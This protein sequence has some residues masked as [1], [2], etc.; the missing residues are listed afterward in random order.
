MHPLRILRSQRPRGRTVPEATG[1]D[2]LGGAA[3]KVA[4]KAEALRRLVR[5]FVSAWW[6][7]F[8]GYPWTVW[9]FLTKPFERWYVRVAGLAV[10][11]T[12]ALTAAVNAAL[13]SVNVRALPRA[14]AAVSHV[15]E[16][17]VRLG[18]VKYAMPVTG[19]VGATPLA[20]LGP[21]SLGPSPLEGSSVEVQEVVVKVAPLASLLQRAVV[22]RVELE[23]A[24][25]E[26]VQCDNFS[27]FGFP[28][29]TEP[30]CRDFLPGLDKPFPEQQPRRGKPPRKPS[31][32]A[33]ATSSSLNGS[34]APPTTPGSS[35]DNDSSNSK[36]DG[37]SSSSS[38]RAE[39]T[40]QGG[41]GDAAALEAA[42][43]AERKAGGPGEPQEASSAHAP[44]QQQQQ[45]HLKQQRHRRQQQ[46]QQPPEEN[47]REPPMSTGSSLEESRAIA[48]RLIEEQ[49]A[50]QR[51][52]PELSVPGGKQHQPP[53]P[54]PAP[55]APS[56]AAAAA[57]APAAAPQAATPQGHVW[58]ALDR[59]V[60]RKA[61]LNVQIFGEEVPRA[62][63][64]AEAFVSL[65]KGYR[66][67]ELDVKGRI[68]ERDPRNKKLTMDNAHAHVN[69]RPFTPGAEAPA[70]GVGAAT[71]FSIQGARVP[72]H[73]EQQEIVDVQEK[74]L[75]LQK[76]SLSCS[77]GGEEG[78]EEGRSE[79]PEGGRGSISREGIKGAA[80]V[81]SLSSSSET[82]DGEEGEGGGGGVGEK[83]KLRV[84]LVARHIGLEDRWPDMAVSIQ[85]EDLHAPNVERL[86]PIPLDINEGRVSGEL[87]LRSHNEETWRF[88]SL[89]GRVKCRGL[90]F[91]FWD[92]PDSLS[93][94]N[95]DLLFE[96]DRLYLHNASGHFGAVP[97]T[98]AGDMDIN[99][100]GGHYRLS[101]NVPSVDINAL[102]ASLGARPLP[103]SVS[104][105]IR[106]VL[107][108][109]GPLEFPVFSGTAVAI[110]PTASQAA[111]AEDTDAK[112]AMLSAPG[113][114]GAY[115]KVPVLSASAVFTFD[116]STAAC[117]VHSFQAEPVGGGSLAGSGRLWLA[118]EAERDPRA[119]RFQMQGRSL[120]ASQLLERYAGGS[121][122]PLGQEIGAL[123]VKGA[124]EG[125]L[126]DATIS[127]RWQVPAAGARGNLE[128]TPSGLSVTGAS[129]TFNAKATAHT[130]LPD[131]ALI[132]AA[133]TQSE[134]T[135]AGKPRYSGADLDL[136][137]Q[138]F[139]AVPP[140]D[141]KK[142]QQHKQQQQQE[143]PVRLK[144]SGRA[145]L[146]GK[147]HEDEAGA[148]AFAGDL[149][150]Q[151]L[152][153]NQLRL[154]R[155]LTGKLSVTEQGAVLKA[156]GQRPDE[157]LEALVSMP[158]NLAEANLAPPPRA[159]Q[160]HQ[161]QQ[162]KQQQVKKEDEDEEDKSV[163]GQV[164][165]RLGRL[166]LGA[167]VDEKDGT[168]RLD[169]KELP[170]DELELGSL[171]GTVK[172]AAL[173]CRLA[174]REARGTIRVSGPR[175]NGLQGQ[176]LVGDAA[177]DGSRVKL[178]RIA[179]QQAR[180]SYVLE[181]EYV[182]PDASEVPSSPRD[183]A[184]ML[185][186]AAA[187][188]S[189][190]S[191]GL[192]QQ[193]PLLGASSEGQ[194]HMKLTVPEAELE[195]IL[196]AARLLSSAAAEK[197]TDYDRAKEAFLKRVPDF[198][199]HAEQLHEAL[200]TMAQAVLAEV[201]GQGDLRAKQEKQQQQQQ[202][203]KASQHLPGLQDLKGRWS[204]TVEA[205][206]G[207]AAAQTS[208]SSSPE[209]ST[210][211]AFD[212]EGK[213]W[214]GGA[215][216][217]DT[218]T[219]RGSFNDAEGLDLK[220][221][222][223]QA[224]DAV[225]LVHGRLLGADQDAV[226]VLN[227]F[228]AVLLSPV[229]RSTPAFE[230]A[231]PAASS[232]S[233][234]STQGS[235]SS[236]TSSSSSSSGASGR[237]PG[238][239]GYFGS[240]G[241]SSWSRNN[242]AAQEQDKYAGFADSPVNG[243]LFVHGSVRGSALQ[244]QCNVAVKLLNGAVGPT[245]LA[246]AAAHVEVDAKQ[247]LG[248]HL[249]MQP[250]DAPGH[251]KVVGSVPLGPS[252]PASAAPP[253]S[254]GSSS[255]SS[256]SD[257][258]VEVEAV[259]KDSGMML[260]SVVSPE[261]RWLSG[262]A[263]VA[264]RLSGTAAEPSVEGTA[265][266]SKA[267][268]YCRPFRYPITNLSATANVDSKRVE[269]DSLEAQVGKKGEIR[270]SGSLPIQQQPQTP[271]QKPPPASG[272]E[273]AGGD[274]QASG[275]AISV[276][277]SDLDLK[278]RNMYTGLFDGKLSLRGSVAK[279][280]VGGLLKF[281]RGTAYLIE[282]PQSGSGG[283]GNA[284]ASAS[285]AA[286]PLEDGTEEQG[287]IAKAFTA[288]T[289]GKRPQASSKA[290]QRQPGAP[291][292]PSAPSSSSSQGS[293]SS[294]SS[295]DVT[296]DGLKVQL[297]PDLRAVYP[298]VLNFGVSGEVE[299]SGPATEAV[300]PKGSIRF[301]NGDINLVAT[302]LSL[303][304]DQPNS[305]T[306]RPEAGLDPYLDVVLQ[307]EEMRV[308]IQGPA[309]DVSVSYTGK[310]GEPLEG[311]DPTKLARRIED[312]LREAILEEDGQIAFSQLA[313]SAV[314]SV[315]PRMETHGQLGKARWRLVS[316]PSL[317]GLMSVDAKGDLSNLLAGLTA[318]T[319]VEVQFGKSLQAAMARKM[320]G[321]EMGTEVTLLYHINP[322]VRMRFSMLGPSPSLV[323]QYS[324]EGVP[325]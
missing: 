70:A 113:A 89:R 58:V 31:Q 133:V 256:G 159:D 215:Y 187:S 7:Y 74:L 140:P 117:T 250:L 169:A 193:A 114:V 277:V 227:D 92:S 57:A 102:R 246:E 201:V 85:A 309:S 284:P 216:K 228:P 67:L 160:Q 116:T 38:R 65:G 237:R 107:H 20:A 79:V 167:Q 94:A 199:K 214:S 196:P 243:K 162:H 304:R 125:S 222:S 212:L 59:V 106:G 54:P 288:L 97:I 264:V 40:T 298:V 157:A 173:D 194:W 233:S 17:D 122:P 16:R 181:G 66:T 123:F 292:R 283:G 6:S 207:G 294:S 253:G 2:G 170:L 91:H 104:G 186:E 315:M 23:G 121:K 119:I 53:P 149:Q 8:I 254:E 132:K 27:W 266:V 300:R 281:S 245:R 197:H 129:R 155:Q 55:S 147:V 279:P 189:P 289:A 26:L 217:L 260:A 75:L 177:W 223:V 174:A 84:R 248:F 312:Q 262:S 263:D 310:E 148:A 30:S 221:L 5:N 82:G 322:N 306:F 275:D 229:L 316:A 234:N 10:L 100:E 271:R 28:D 88:P 318:G 25:G 198:G 154:A 314:S 134:A 286:E 37:G 185:E 130:L 200:E 62:I 317:P 47:G 184:S 303:A 278:V 86:L 293:A 178:E 276:A 73:L 146:S 127:G 226:V 258:A 36:Q 103:L 204:G 209:G 101:A 45:Q 68:A 13:P 242:A 42:G 9:S 139:E 285:A 296:L 252:A 99:P 171:R 156:R 69:L 50:A 115:D 46:Q 98:L 22:L 141:K 202:G 213:G 109:T 143:Q 302:K 138:D 152:K 90:D 105:A 282:A 172:E 299:L 41:S 151:G 251:L 301:E 272:P 145:R 240:W 34:S 175:F 96:G 118:P 323:F 247:Q 61:D 126:L 270:V 14:E 206:G 120:S 72:Q 51:H 290:A 249:Q 131:H 112:E 83:G 255:S 142:Q 231:V 208:A 297:G 19:L 192:H 244:P 239:S 190:S 224:D 43:N 238:G 137:L 195:E 163:S 144:M 111:A 108:V 135:K 274:D 18:G 180:S 150:L 220:Q 12:F 236:S 280:V 232:S 273:A 4:K 203:P 78:G 241:L 176:S 307:G 77:E 158:I 32:F 287:G 153:L 49:L 1:R 325:K 219:A 76:T 52:A 230:N 257:A 225:L 191:P 35:S 268:V 311:E 80:S 21:V 165:L 259:L 210:S 110:P 44:E 168:L 136:T 124:M 269:I 188:S 164:S 128:V 161:R 308:V 179:L 87:R 321:N 305:V 205:R 166:F 235:S 218:V 56:P 11:L 81:A 48:S 71:W 324:G 182:I 64:D 33:S 291:A 265:H 313:A 211:V 267:S 60:L 63:R 15:L 261:F 93:G 320:K 295:S 24:R 95:M 183:V 319:E 3:S 29:D 39:E